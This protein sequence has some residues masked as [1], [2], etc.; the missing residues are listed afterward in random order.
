[1]NFAMLRA[2]GA[3]NAP[4]L[5][6]A[7]S[8]ANH[9][10]LIV[11]GIPQQLAQFHRYATK[12][13]EELSSLQALRQRGPRED[14]EARKEIQSQFSRG[15]LHD[16][17]PARQRELEDVVSVMDAA[18]ES[19]AS[20]EQ[21]FANSLR[22]PEER[23]VHPIARQGQIE[24]AAAR[25]IF[26]DVIKEMED[27]NGNITYV[28][29]R[30]PSQDAQPAEV[31]RWID[32]PECG[33]AMH[34][35][36]K[37]VVAAKSGLTPMIDRLAAVLALGETID[38]PNPAPAGGDVGQRARALKILH[39]QQPMT[40]GAI[41]A[42]AVEP[43]YAFAKEYD[44]A[45]IADHYETILPALAERPTDANLEALAKGETAY[46]DTQ[47][48]LGKRV[49]AA[50]RYA[51]L[52]KCRDETIERMDQALRKQWEDYLA[53]DRLVHPTTL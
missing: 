27:A 9:S 47:P 19:I 51:I 50:A 5:N 34:D 7:F 45:T 24:V 52:V 49:S 14:E 40:V 31:C 15:G 21:S 29:S 6:H 42:L 39:A 16:G 8:C 1:M 4:H 36:L 43:L 28:V 37:A 41:A 18:A 30:M 12:S 46:W 10:F 44:S 2:G 11:R 25:E 26:S 32:T 48:G 38:D 23:A 20:G 35:L 17:L 22:S 33:V 3:R 13:T 53:A